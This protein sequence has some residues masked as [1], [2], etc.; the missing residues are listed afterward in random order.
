MH[1][2]ADDFELKFDPGVMVRLAAQAGLNL[3]V[4]ATLPPS[5]RPALMTALHEQ[6][7]LKLDSQ[8]G[9]VDVLVIDHVEAPT[10]D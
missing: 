3:P 9:P 2:A 4:P 6:L 10:P 7:G 8:R 5:D 1:R